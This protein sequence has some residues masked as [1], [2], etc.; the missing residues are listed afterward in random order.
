MKSLKNSLRGLKR[1]SKVKLKCPKCKN[2]LVEG[3][4]YDTWD[5]NTCYGTWVFHPF[6]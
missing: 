1:K 6:R 2:K 4:R 3:E 5:C